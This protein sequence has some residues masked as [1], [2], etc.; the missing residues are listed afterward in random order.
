[1]QQLQQHLGGEN[2]FSRVFFFS[3]GLVF[4]LP[5]WFKGGKAAV[6]QSVS[7]VAAAAAAALACR[8]SLGQLATAGGELSGFFFAF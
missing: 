1:M 5:I 7:V 6:S 8:R 4:F 3:F 2:W